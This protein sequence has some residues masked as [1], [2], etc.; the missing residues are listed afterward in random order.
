MSRTAKHPPKCDRFTK[1]HRVGAHQARAK[2]VL[3]AMR[4]ARV[5]CMMHPFVLNFIRHRAG[6]DAP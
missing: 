1:K 5:E 3:A 6:E 4:D 2:R